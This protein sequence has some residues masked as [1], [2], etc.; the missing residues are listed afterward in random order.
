MYNV[1][2][3]MLSLTQKNIDKHQEK[4]IMQELR[5]TNIHEVA[6]LAGVSAMTV[7]RTFNASGPVAEKTRARIMKAAAKLGYRPNIMARSLRSGKTN[8]IGLLWSLAGPHDSGLQVQGITQRLMDKGYACHIADSLSDPKIIKQCLAD[9]CGRNTDGII[10]QVN[11]GLIEDESIMALLKQI[12]NVILV[13]PAPIKNRN[14]DILILDRT[15]AIKETID[16]FS[17]TGRK[18][19]IFLLGG[20]DLQRQTVFKEHL[21]EHGMEV[22][23]KSIVLVTNRTTG[24]FRAGEWNKF[25]ETLRENFGSKMPFDSLLCTCD[26]GAAAVINYLE[27]HGYK[28]PDDIA[29]SGFNDSA[30]APF[31]KPPIAS[32]NRMIEE[33][34]D[35]VTNMLLNRIENPDMNLQ[36]NLI[37]MKFVWRESAG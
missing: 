32:V 16:H 13:S 15:Q 17:S 19:T 23:D 29:V 9:F 37:N 31:F 11:E 3:N 6:E 26:E 28:V 21:A 8:T 7:T 36:K 35:T 14:A 25:A 34:S 22:N 30:M 20:E 12:N 2:V 10:F 24:R 27:K 4:R 5:K 33:V 18:K 1:I